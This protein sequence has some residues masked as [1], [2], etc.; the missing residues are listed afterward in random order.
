MRISVLL[1]AM[2]DQGR[3][4]L[5]LKEA[6]LE[7]VTLHLAGSRRRRSC[8]SDSYHYQDV[9]LEGHEGVE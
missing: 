4:C 8:A 9:A 7:G 5:G 6:S 3:I 2:Q 1:K